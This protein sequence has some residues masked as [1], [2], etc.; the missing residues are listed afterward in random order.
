MLSLQYHSRVV[1][2]LR[3]RPEINNSYLLIISEG[4]GKHIPALAARE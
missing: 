4:T 1:A 2:L 3:P